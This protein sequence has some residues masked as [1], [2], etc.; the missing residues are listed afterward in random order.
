MILKESS[1]ILVFQFQ[2][3]FLSEMFFMILSSYPGVGALRQLPDD[4]VMIASQS[5]S[6]ACK[7]R[8]VLFCCK[9]VATC[10]RGK[11]FDGIAQSGA[12]HSW[13]VLVE[14]AQEKGFMAFADFTEHP[15]DSLVHQVVRMAE[16]PVGE[17]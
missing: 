11:A 4:E 12:R 10:F 8:R 16:E 13:R 7:K 2:E 3:K 5:H 17:S 6:D 1:V 15:S 9:V 14:I